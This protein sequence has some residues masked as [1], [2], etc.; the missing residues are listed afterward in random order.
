M[1]FRFSLCAITLLLSYACAGVVSVNQQREVVLDSCRLRGLH[2]VWISTVANT[3]GEPNGKLFQNSN[4]CSV[5]LVKSQ[6]TVVI[7]YSI[8]TRV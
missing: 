8:S 3:A 5:I 7:Q 1:L 6:Y 4:L 2:P